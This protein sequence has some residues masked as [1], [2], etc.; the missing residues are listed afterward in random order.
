MQSLKLLRILPG[1]IV[2]RAVVRCAALEGLCDPP[3]P[4]ISLFS[5]ILVARVMIAIGW[6]GIGKWAS[7]FQVDVLILIVH[8]QSANIS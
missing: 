2:R 1:Y 8:F 5:K 7:F 6:E 4:K 3:T